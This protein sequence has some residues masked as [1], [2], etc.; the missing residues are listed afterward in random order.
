[1]HILPNADIP[2]IYRPNS[3]VFVA[4]FEEG[5]ETQSG[6]GPGAA[7]APEISEVPVLQRGVLDAL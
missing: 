7:K 4:F 6:E 2:P 1:M 5:L 3:S